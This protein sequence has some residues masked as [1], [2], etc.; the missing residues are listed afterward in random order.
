[1]IF[2]RY[3]AA[4]FVRPNETLGKLNL[5]PARMRVGA[6][7]MLGM[8]LL[9]TLVS[10]NLAVIGGTPNQEPWLRIPS[11]DYFYWASYFYA[12]ILLSGWLFASAVT[13]LSARALGGRGSFDDSVALFGFATA[14]ATVPALA[15]DL[16]LTSAQAIGWMD[17]EPWFRSVTHCGV[18]FYIVWVYLAAY[19][20]YF[21][22]FYPSAARIVHRL[23]W[24]RAVVAGL[25][26][27]VAYQVF[28][29]V[30]IR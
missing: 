16:A 7:A 25:A 17:Y 11:R 18:W 30:F 9:Y 2:R 14:A 22:V 15:P 20:V 6:A 28:I 10:V 27:F 19:L 8:S 23:N 3:L 5:D 12:P 24:P 1:M 26:G 13:H 21:C 29:F 4:V